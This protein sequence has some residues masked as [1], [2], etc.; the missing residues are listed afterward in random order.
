MRAG[1]SSERLAK[2]LG[3]ITSRGEM[4]RNKQR[5]GLR[6]AVLE[7]LADRG[8]LDDGFGFTSPVVGEAFCEGVRRQNAAAFKK[9]RR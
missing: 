3:F 5:A 8:E 4:R 1:L 7:A 9:R 6:E 2:A